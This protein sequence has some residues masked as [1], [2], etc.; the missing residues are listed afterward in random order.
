M[1]LLASG[2]MVVAGEG[3]A[4]HSF[5]TYYQVIIIIYKAAITENVNNKVINSRLISL[6][7]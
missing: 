1:Q 4:V 5:Q 2:A 7:L 6:F 3:V